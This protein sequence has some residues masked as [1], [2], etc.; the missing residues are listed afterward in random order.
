MKP[1]WKRLAARIDD[2]TLRERAILFA[3]GSLII[4][5][6]AYAALIDPALTRQK[7][8]VDSVNRDQSQLTAVRGEIGKLLREDGR[9]SSPE[10]EAV[11]A[12]EDR[13]A[14]TQA[15]LSARQREFVT[16]ERLPGLLREILAR[17]RRLKLESLRLVS[18]S[19]PKGGQSERRGVE[20]RL[21]GTYLDLLQLLA[22]LEGLPVKLLW[23]SLDLQTRQYPE[24]DLTLNVYALSAPQSNSK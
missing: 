11:R 14:Q 4:V 3:A 2:M 10:Q 23:G 8:L 1:D 5:A 9:G 20:I 16:P 12:L 17:S 15:A 22:E 7:V 19:A 13:L 21:T 24:V 18:S 6:L